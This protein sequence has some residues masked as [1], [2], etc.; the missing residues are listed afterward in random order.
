MK[1][2]STESASRGRKWSTVAYP[3]KSPSKRAWKFHLDLVTGS[4]GDFGKRILVNRTG[5][6]QNAEG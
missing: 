3:A 4:L 1:N 2:S 6:N 5:R